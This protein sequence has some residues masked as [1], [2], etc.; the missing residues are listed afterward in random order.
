MSKVSSV[1]GGWPYLYQHL[2]SSFLPYNINTADFLIV[3]YS[4]SEG[5]YSYGGIM[6]F[7]GVEKTKAMTACLN[8]QIEE[9]NFDIKNPI[10]LGNSLAILTKY[11]IVDE[12][13][14]SP[15]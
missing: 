5:K 15:R 1:E 14:K 12:G 4:E 2:N 8:T 3:N 10:K 9:A 7:G 13:R 11:S 6:S